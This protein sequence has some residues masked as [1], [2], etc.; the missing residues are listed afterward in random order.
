MRKDKEQAIVL[1]KSGMSYSEIIARMKVPRSTLSD[2]FRDQKWSN[3]IAIECA[4]KARNS[5][6]IRLMVLNTVRGSRLKKLYEEARQEAI[7]E[8]EELKYH[9]LFMAGLMIYWGEGNKISKYRI[10]IANS[11]ANMIKVFKLFL[12]NVCRVNTYRVWLLLYP[13]LNE[14]QCKDFWISKCGLKQEQFTKTITIKGK[15]Q[16][17]RLN[18]GVCNI[19][20][21]S[22]YL[23]SKIL[24]WIELTT[25]ELT[26]EKY[27]QHQSE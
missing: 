13:D 4:R 21:S 8:F 12:E 1:R 6:A 26:E 15:S 24:K 25:S 5:S 18:N 2:W 11:E 10:S 22:A 9:P 7:L 19:G 17:K 23:K 14:M 27:L 3:D 16:V 20:L